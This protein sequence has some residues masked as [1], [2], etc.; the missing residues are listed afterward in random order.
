VVRDRATGTI[1]SLARGGSA[2]IVTGT[3]EVTVQP[4]DGVTGGI[5]HQGP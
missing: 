2:D 1:L 4:S 5:I 3:A